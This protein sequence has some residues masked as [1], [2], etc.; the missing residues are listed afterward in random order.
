[1]LYEVYDIS[2]IVF[3]LLSS[4]KQRCLK[5]A[6]MRVRTVPKSRGDAA[7]FCRVSNTCKCTF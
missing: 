4:Q 7:L 3:F 6:L 2:N 5:H 1:M